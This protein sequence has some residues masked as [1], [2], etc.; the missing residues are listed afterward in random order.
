MHRKL[1][2]PFV[3]LLAVALIAASCGNSG[4]E[5]ET[6][7]D[8]TT[9][10]TTTAAPD[11]GGDDDGS[12]DDGSDD[13]DGSGDGDG[14]GDDDDEPAWDRTTFVPLEGVP[15]VTD[16]EIRVA[17]IGTDELNPLGTC[18]L[19]CYITGIQAYFDEIN[20]TGGIFG[21]DLVIDHVL[22]DQLFANQDRSLEVIADDDVFAVFNA[23]LGAGGWGDLH[24]AGI[25]NFTWNIHAQ[26]AA[27]RDTVFGHFAVGCDTC[28]QRVVP[29]LMT[30]AGASTIATL[31]YGVSE[32]SKVCANAVADS[33]ELY[34]DELGI[35]VG[36][37]NDSLDFG[38]SSG[39]G[40]EVSQMIDAGVDFISTCLDLN[41]MRTLADELVRQGVRDQITMHHPNTY[42]VGFVAEA[43]NLFD[44]DYVAPQFRALE[45]PNDSPLRAIYDARVE[46]GDGPIAEQ[47]MVGFI[48]ADH[49][50]TGLLKAGPEFS[51]QAVIDALNN[52]D[53]Y[54]AQGLINPIDWSR[55]HTPPTED[56][57]TNDYRLECAAMVQMQDGAFVP[58]QDDAFM[59]WDN[60]STDWAEPQPFDTFDVFG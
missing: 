26:E 18:I 4:D 32:N 16:E 44:G 11:D 14:S 7:T 5:D 39:I 12:D 31:G 57:P 51:R 42:D 24:E 2:V 33:V 47:S 55:Q 30:Q 60:S 38:L 19:P 49:L 23:T 36:F 43:G 29:W 35:S 3:L 37:V 50:Y 46:G 45:Y 58:F 10:T 1:S 22:D 54:D 21:R 34:G 25:P 15:G 9:T 6:V 48:N 56:D 52:G 27:N 13:A 8:D 28:S 17:V 20:E 53:F 40:P 59:C 41:A